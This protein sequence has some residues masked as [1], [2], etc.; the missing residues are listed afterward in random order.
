MSSYSFSLTSL[1]ILHKFQFEPF[2][3]VNSLFQSE[4]GENAYQH[5]PDPLQIRV[6]SDELPIYFI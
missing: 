6:L 3:Q 4:I 2:F 1:D 5:F